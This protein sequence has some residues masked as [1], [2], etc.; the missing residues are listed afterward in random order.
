MH[1]IRLTVSCNFSGHN[2]I[3]KASTRIVVTY[4]KICGKN[5]VSASI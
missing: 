3:N 2:F 4:P 1:K 5:I